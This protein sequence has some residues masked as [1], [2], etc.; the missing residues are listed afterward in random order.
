MKYLFWFYHDLPCSHLHQWY[1]PVVVPSTSLLLISYKIHKKKKNKKKK[2][3]N[4]GVVS[5]FFHV[6]M[7]TR[8]FVH[9]T[10]TMLRKLVSK[11]KTKI[12]LLVLWYCIKLWSSKM[13]GPLGETGVSWHRT[14]ALLE[15]W[16]FSLPAKYD[17]IK[18]YHLY[19]GTNN[20]HM[21]T[22][23]HFQSC[24]TNTVGINQLCLISHLLSKCFTF[25]ES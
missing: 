17:F 15:Q 14:W 10:I 22:P 24:S 9:K 11:R 23:Y 7:D 6:N 12:T 16:V 20:T 2:N 1:C 21:H 4:Y 13:E 8:Y 19:K 18:E 3:P 5:F 25:Q